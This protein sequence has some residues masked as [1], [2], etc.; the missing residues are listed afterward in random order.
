MSNTRHQKS[1]KTTLQVRIGNQSLYRNTAASVFC[2]TLSAMGLEQVSK[3]G[4]TSCG[5]PLVSKTPPAK[6]RNHEK[7]G[8]WFIITHSSTREKRSLLEEAADA[9]S[10]PIKVRIVTEAQVVE[11][12]LNDRY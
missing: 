9:L 10:I 11:D 12:V 8:E 3:V 1:P 2:H 7:L 4:L 5:M 6:D